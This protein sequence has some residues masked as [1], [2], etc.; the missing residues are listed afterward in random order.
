MTL[1]QLMN[2][3]PREKPLDYI[4]ADGGYCGIFRTIACVGDSLS[5]GEFVAS[6]EKD[7]LTYHD[8]FPSS[9]G[10]YLGRAAGSQVYNFSCGGMSARCYCQEFARNN[11]YWSPVKAAQAYYIALG[12]NDLFYQ[13]HPFGSMDDICPE[14][15]EQNAQTFAGAHDPSV[16]G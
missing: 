11:N 15:P 5:S 1:E 4:P 3:D 13:G 12:V 7:E 10:Q 8:M 16:S 14:D 2:P 9:W 6:N